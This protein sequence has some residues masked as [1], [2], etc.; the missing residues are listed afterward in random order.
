MTVGAQ[1]PDFDLE[2]S[3]G[4]RVSNAD[5]EGRRTVLYFYPKD[6]TPGCT[7]EGQEFTQLNEAF[8]AAGVTVYGVSPD[9]SKSHERFIAKCAL[10]IPLIS[11]PER[12]LIDSQGLWVEK[13]FMGRQYMGV[14]RT[15][16][17]IGPDG[18]IVREWRDVK[19]SGHAEEVLETVNSG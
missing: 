1:L 12:R 4:G 17:L 7:L 14:A 15:T 6:D 19:P 9:T 11:D 2:T 8:N 3:G 13:K 10:A 16:L 5:L 18:T